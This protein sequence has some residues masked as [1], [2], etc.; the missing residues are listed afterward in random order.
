MLTDNIWLKTHERMNLQPSRMMTSKSFGFALVMAVSLSGCGAANAQHKSMPFQT[1]P[2]VT[3][4]AKSVWD[5]PGTFNIC[6]QPSESNRLVGCMTDAL[7]RAGASNQVVMSMEA[8]SAGGDPAYVSAYRREGSI[9]IATVTHPFRANTNDETRLVGSDGAIINV[10]SD[11]VTPAEE[12]GT[13]Y[14]TLLNQHPGLEPFPPAKLVRVDQNED[15][16]TAL[17]FDTAMRDCHACQSDGWLSVEYKFTA[18]GR[19]LGHHL[20]GIDQT[21]GGIFPTD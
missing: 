6:Y 9:G 4:N 20:V 8:L 12:N 5:N 19:F 2:P 1:N 15:G 21:N 10:D 16:S 11:P 17:R 7:Y 3:I 14:S 13:L 18:S